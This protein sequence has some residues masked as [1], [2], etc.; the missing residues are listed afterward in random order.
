MAFEFDDLPQIGLCKSK[1]RELKTARE[2][3][4]YSPYGYFISLLPAIDGVVHPELGIKKALT[5]GI[6]IRSQRSS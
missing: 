3:Q 1:G 4:A 5:F 2:R 6:G